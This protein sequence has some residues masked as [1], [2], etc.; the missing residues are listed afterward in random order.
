MLPTRDDEDLLA[1]L[2]RPFTIADP[3][4]HPD[5]WMTVTELGR[6]F[7][8]E[9]RLI[10]D[11]LYRGHVPKRDDGRAHAAHVMAYVRDRGKR[12]GTVPIGEA[13][14]PDCAP[15]AQR[16]AGGLYPT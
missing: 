2:A 15:A 13:G 9:R 7:R 14:D 12:G 6:V 8:C 16:H 10:S 11:M 3:E 1:R 5:G 4:L